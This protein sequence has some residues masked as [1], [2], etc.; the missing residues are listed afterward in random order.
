MSD[1]IE[2]RIELA[3][4]PERVWRALSNAREFGTWFGARLEGDFVPGATVRGPMAIAGFEHLTLEIAIERVEEARLLAFRWHP[5]AIEAG[6]DYSKEATTL[7]ELRI[8]P[9]AGGTLLVVTES[10]FDKIPPGRRPKA[11]EMNSKGWEAQLQNVARHVGSFE[12]R[13]E[14]RFKRTPA[15][16][17]AAIVDPAQMTQYFITHGSARMDAAERIEW[18]WEDVGAQTTVAITEIVPDRKIAFRWPADGPGTN[19][20]LTIEA[21]GERTKLVATEGP[22]EMTDAGVKRAL[23]QTQGWTD[24]SCSL[25]AYLHHAINLRAGK[26]ADHVA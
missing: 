17:F 10:G 3:A 14:S 26:P 18:K 13:V 23:G 25:R 4:K 16:V 24:F 19:V 15:E 8:E 11:F 21:D 2:K 20:T 1:R 12:L 6:V 9:T 22:F 5:C 7:V